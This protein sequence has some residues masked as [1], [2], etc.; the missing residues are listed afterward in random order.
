MA[1]SFHAWVLEPSR[2]GSLPLEHGSVNTLWHPMDS[3]RLLDVVPGPDGPRL[4]D[5]PVTGGGPVVDVRAPPGLARPED[6]SPDGATLLFNRGVADTGI[7]TARLDA[8]DEA[9][10]PLVLTGETNLNT[11]FGPDGRW[12][13]YRASSR[14][15]GGIYVQM[16]RRNTTGTWV[17][18]Q[19]LI[20]V[21]CAGDR[22]SGSNGSA[23]ASSKKVMARST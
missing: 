22:P 6:V 21:Q 23:S 1:R 11:R 12:I 10:Q 17:V 14:D 2:S 18:Y 13:L 7:F 16:N 20:S 9:P 5:R 8:P 3:G 15:A 19:A 4:V